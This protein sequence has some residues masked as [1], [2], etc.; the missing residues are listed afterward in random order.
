MVEG[1]FGAAS[2]RRLSPPASGSRAPGLT[3]LVTGS[4]GFIGFHVARRL[5]EQ[6]DA[7]V[8]IDAYVPYYDLRIKQARSKLLCMYPAYQEIKADLAGPDVMD[9]VIAQHVPDAIVH[10]AEQPGVRHS[11]IK[12]G[13]FEQGNVRATLAVLE[14]VRKR[15]AGP[16]KSSREYRPKIVFGSSVSVYGDTQQLPFSE[17]D[18]PGNPL[19]LYAATKRAGELLAGV[20]S[21]SHG[22]DCIGLRLCN[23][24]GPWGRPDTAIWNFLLAI[25]D[26]HPVDVYNQGGLKR[27]CIYIDDVVDGVMASLRSREAVSGEIINLG[28]GVPAGL[29]EMIRMLEGAA[30]RTA[31]LRMLPMQPGEAQTTWADISKA[32]RLL[33][34]QPRTDLRT[35]L[36]LFVDWFLERRREDPLF[37]NL[38]DGMSGRT[39]SHGALDGALQ[40]R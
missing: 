5:L 24:Y 3:I 21:R 15:K 11:L 38:S 34:W 9:E 32:K 12:P 8:G 16:G 17:K 36:R 1:T 35:G 22:F 20:Y 25:L 40:D 28:S 31:R 33:D 7:V 37:G 23:V 39:L 14:A 30:S 29:R 13:A 18:A 6:G 27:D 10:L 19:S 4:A 2:K 26:G